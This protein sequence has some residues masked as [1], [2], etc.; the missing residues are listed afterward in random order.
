MAAAAAWN[1]D[2]EAAVKEVQKKLASLR[3]YCKSPAKLERAIGDA[4]RQ[5]LELNALIRV[6]QR[7][8]QA[9]AR[10]EPLP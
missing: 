5:A 1:S 9:E 8:A 7:T 4:Q 6:Y 3:A 2:P 10:R